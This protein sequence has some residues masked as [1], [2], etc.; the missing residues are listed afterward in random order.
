MSLI[1]SYRPNIQKL[2]YHLLISR[3]KRF[4]TDSTKECNTNT[5]DSIEKFQPKPESN[6]NEYHQNHHSHSHIVSIYKKLFK[7]DYST[8]KLISNINTNKEPT[9]G[10][11]LLHHH[12]SFHHQQQSPPLLSQASIYRKL[13]FLLKKKKKTP[14]QYREISIQ[15]AANSEYAA[16]GKLHHI[17]SEVTKKNHLCNVTCL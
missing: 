15:F 5:C 12:S 3:Q 13:M 7:I 17:L 14:Q 9:L 2:T 11:S 6:H 16:A 4:S 8:P 10:M 1:F